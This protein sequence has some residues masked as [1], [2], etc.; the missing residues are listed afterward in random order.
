MKLPPDHVPRAFLEGARTIVA[1]PKS[2]QENELPLKYLNRLGKTD[3]RRFVLA[4]DHF[5]AIWK[6]RSI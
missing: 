4:R 1:S 5:R 6:L 3:A 2:C